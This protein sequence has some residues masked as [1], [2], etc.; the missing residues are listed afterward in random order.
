MGDR[1][2]FEQLIENTQNMVYSIVY[3]HVQ[4][5]DTAED[6]AQDTYVKAFTSLNGLKE[7]L[8]IRSWLTSIAHHTAID[9]VRKKKEKATYSAFDHEELKDKQGI[10]KRELNTLIWQVLEDLEPEEKELVILKYTE[11]FSYKELSDVFKVS[12][13]AVRVKL[14]RLHQRLE[15]KLRFL[16]EEFYEL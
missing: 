8:K 13:A 2:A 15:E 3:S 1:K 16:K 4:N 12:E 11:S 14:C 6:L 7:P 9:W 10:E 5:R